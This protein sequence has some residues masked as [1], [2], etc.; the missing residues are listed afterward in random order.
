MNFRFYF[1]LV[2]I[3]LFSSFDDI[4]LKREKDESLTLDSL[5]YVE[6]IG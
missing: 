4:Y 5:I 2:S 6:F 3:R 1:F